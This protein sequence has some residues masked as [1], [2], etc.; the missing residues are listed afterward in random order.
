MEAAST[1]RNSRGRPRV[2]AE[3]V[4][5]GDH[6]SLRRCGHAR[7]MRTSACR[8]YRGFLRVRHDMR[9]VGPSV[10][11][12]FCLEPVDATKMQARRLESSVAAILQSCSDFT[13]IPGSGG[14]PRVMRLIL[15]GKVGNRPLAAGFA[16]DLRD[17]RS[18]TPWHAVWIDG[19][20]PERC[21]LGERHDPS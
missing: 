7:W 21:A 10:A 20:H 9:F 12:V 4:H 2:D 17:G 5:Q 11:P 6:A 15:G 19:L 13:K 1:H 3:D 14:D 16:G 8:T 18:G